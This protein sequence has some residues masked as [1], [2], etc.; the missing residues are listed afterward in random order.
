VRRQLTAAAFAIGVLIVVLPGS[1]ARADDQPNGGNVGSGS[2]QFAGGS[3]LGD[4]SGAVSNAGYQQSDNDTR[5]A[6]HPGTVVCTFY[7]DGTGAEVNLSAIPHVEHSD[8][9]I[10]DRT[11]IDTSTGEV[12]SYDVIAYQPGQP[13]ISPDRLAQMASSTV[14]LPLPEIEFSPP[15]KNPNDFL[16]VN[17][18]T[19][20]RV[21]NWQPLST[22]AVA[23]P[24]VATVT[25]TPVRQEWDFD[26][27]SPDPTLQGGC[28]A[29]GAE[30]DVNK[31]ADQQS[32]PCTFTFHHSSASQPGGAY[33]AHLTVVY[34]VTWTSNI[35]AGGSLG[36][37][38]RTTIRP[39]RVGEAQ[40]VNE[41]GGT[42]P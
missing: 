39:V 37:V 15:L 33:D 21:T 16:L 19:W 29:Q 40:A 41:S 3:L 8:G 4:G 9:V 6:R 34:A 12:V 20:L 22:T 5:P 17:L 14:G 35:G 2:D 24:V 13:P 32:S 23:G 10:L 11:C 36:E 30:Y 26:P 31:P 1:V 42:R 27:S 25:A 28:A 38:R 18:P 7:D